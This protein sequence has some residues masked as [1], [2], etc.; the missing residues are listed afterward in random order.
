MSFFLVLTSLQLKVTLMV[1]D[2]YGLV[3]PAL[4]GVVYLSQLSV[5]LGVVL[6]KKNPAHDLQV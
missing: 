4:H 1:I 2:E 3:L 6:T 5:Q